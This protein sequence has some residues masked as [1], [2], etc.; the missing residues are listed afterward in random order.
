M[1]WVRRLMQLLL[2]ASLIALLL[3][4]TVLAQCAPEDSNCQD[5][6]IIFGETDY[7]PGLG[8][9]RESPIP[10]ESRG[11][12]IGNSLNIGTPKSS[13]LKPSQTPVDGDFARS[14]GETT[15]KNQVLSP[16]QVFTDLVT[17]ANPVVSALPGL[18]PTSCGD[19]CNKTIP[20]GQ[21][22][23]GLQGEDPDSRSTAESD[24]V[25]AATGEFYIEN[26]DLSLPG[27]GVPFV[28]IRTYR[29]QTDFQSEL[30]FGWDHNYNQ[31]LIPS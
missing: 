29:S 9:H 16:S 19:N 17:T 6:I 8:G 5:G 22:N 31:R 20:S 18:L 28:F 10:Q 4:G 3:A 27:K 25:N 26:Y 23:E 1:K 11:G 7:G 21:N 2:P 24:P 13:R 30:G 15:G 12:A 14:T